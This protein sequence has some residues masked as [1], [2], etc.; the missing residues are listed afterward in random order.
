MLGV[1]NKPVM[2]SVIML[3]VV[4][5]PGENLKVVLGRIFNSKIGS[6]AA[7]RGECMKSKRPLLVL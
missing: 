6:F 4:A 7:P 2:L 5:Q 1:A 3:N